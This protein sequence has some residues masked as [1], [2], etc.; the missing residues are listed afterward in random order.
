MSWTYSGD[1]SSSTRD[2]VRF[3]IGDTDETDPQ[4]N[5][6][7]V[8]YLL[9]AN[10]DNSQLAAASCADAIASKYTRLVNK[11]VGD[12]SISYGERAQKYTELAGKL[13][14]DATIALAAPYCGGISVSDKEIDP[15]N[16]DQVRP[17]F[18]V[19]VHDNYGTEPEDNTP[20]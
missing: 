16:S 19:G 11:S 1:P 9:A 20:E 8:E 17:H 4:L 12:L 2:E 18:K 7:E 14:G 10:G 3:L 6:Q 15:D 5:D 13:K